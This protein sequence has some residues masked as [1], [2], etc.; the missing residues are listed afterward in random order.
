MGL[1]LLTDKVVKCR[2][3]HRCGWC[4]EGINPGDP[5]NYR[6]GK[7]EGDFF[8][9]Y[10]HPEC[11]I[12]MFNSDDLDEGFYPHEQKRGKTLEESST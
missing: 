11:D 3:P 6:S 12:A 7:Y 1:V 8:S 4:G 9:D 10:M 2:K 5:A